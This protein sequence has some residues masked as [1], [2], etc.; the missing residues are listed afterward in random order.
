MD[1]TDLRK[2]AM[3]KYMDPLELVKVLEK[4]VSFVRKKNADWAE[5]RSLNIRRSYRLYFIS[6]AFLA[7]SYLNTLL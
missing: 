2:L 7:L 1:S 4:Q 6:L 5:E 3:E